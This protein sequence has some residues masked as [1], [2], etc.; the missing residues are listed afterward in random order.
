MALHY[1]GISGISSGYGAKRATDGTTVRVE[2]PQDATACYVL[3]P[4]RTRA[5]G[6]DRSLIH[7]IRPMM[8]LS[9]HKSSVVGAEAGIGRL[10]VDCDVLVHTV[11]RD[12]W[13]EQ[14]RQQKR[15]RESSPR[16]LTRELHRASLVVCSE[17]IA[18]YCRR[19]LSRLRHDDKTAVACMYHAGRC[20]VA[21]VA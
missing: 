5:S 2:L 18:T 15:R 4:S 13:S 20:Q 21:Q 8:N 17:N 12:N 3:V 6:S 19:R 10:V 1:S 16:E 7:A 14:A 9:C 11:T